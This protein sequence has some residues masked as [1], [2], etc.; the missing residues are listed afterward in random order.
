MKGT[1]AVGL[2]FVSILAIV[3]CAS[4]CGGAGEPEK[5]GTTSSA[6]ATSCGAEYQNGPITT[7]TTKHDRVVY[8]VNYVPVAKRCVNQNGETCF[9]TW[10]EE[11]VCAPSNGLCAQY[12]NSD[13]VDGC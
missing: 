7:G 12:P 6:I 11:Y 4:G 1:P 5:T 10:T 8:D 2:L 13:I 3:A 9:I